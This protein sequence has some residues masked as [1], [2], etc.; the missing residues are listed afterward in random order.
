MKQAYFQILKD[1]IKIP[2][3]SGSEQAIANHILTS[4]CK[5]GWIAELDGLHNILFCPIGDEKDEMLPLLYAHTDTHPNGKSNSHLLPF[6]DIISLDTNGQVQKK[7][8]IQVGFDDKAGVAAILYLMLHTDRKFRAL[9]VT[10]EEIA[11][12]GGSYGRQGGG[13]IDF[14]L[15][16]SFSWVFQQ[17]K[18]VIALDRMGDKE[19]ISAYGNDVIRKKISLCSLDFSKN[20]ENVSKACN[21]PMKAID[22]R[23]IADVYNIRRRFPN[24]DCV[25]LSIGYQDEHRP[26]ES[27]S[28][29]ATLGV[30]H[31]LM[32]LIQTKT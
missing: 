17:S 14:A 3:P 21:F 24:L 11:L 28:I 16:N 20:I 25:N 2:S 13:G 27:L 15:N 23:N 1:L 4:Y 7:H 8:E 5:N 30:I 26:K 9:L 10:Q 6:N 31:F 22:S 18:C 12:N 19:I 29:D 32:C